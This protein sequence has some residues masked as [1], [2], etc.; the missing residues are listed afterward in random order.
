M[1]VSSHA[2]AKS[3][4]IYG[5]GE[6]CRIDRRHRATRERI[7]PARGLVDLGRRA[8]MRAVSGLRKWR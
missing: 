6:V 1:A 8:E 3:K 7:P 5:V 4:E 2:I